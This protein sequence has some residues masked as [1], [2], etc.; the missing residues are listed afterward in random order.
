MLTQEETIEIIRPYY[1]ELL[2]LLSK[3]KARLQ[4]VDSERHALRKTTVANFFRD[5]A[6]DEAR[7]VFDGRQAHGITLID[8][9]D[10]SFFIEF[11]GFPRGIDGAAWVKIKKVNDKFLTSNIPT[12]KAVNFNSQ[13]SIGFT[14]QPYLEGVDWNK[15]AKILQPT[16]IN[17]GH[18]WDE[19]G[20][21]IQDVVLTCP[22]NNSSFSWIEKMGDSGFE[23]GISS[24][25]ADNVANFP[26][27]LEVTNIKPKRISAKNSTE[28]EK[29]KKDGT[30]S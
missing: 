6:V 1:M 30:R 2:T 18:Q 24:D 4:L 21:D 28:K 22:E 29:V 19:L 16:Y 15:N 10:S 25:A 13:K 27:R 7:L 14:Q 17:L 8:E 20:T 3:A 26:I 23:M 12:R 11:S 5:L 9:K